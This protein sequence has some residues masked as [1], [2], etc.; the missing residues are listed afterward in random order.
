MPSSAR[1]ASGEIITVKSKA[2]V[3]SLF[4]NVLRDEERM[5]DEG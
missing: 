3:K 1:E 2:V 5:R 4:I